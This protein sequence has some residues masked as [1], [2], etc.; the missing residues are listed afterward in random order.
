MEPG[1]IETRLADE[2]IAAK[3]LK[4]Y[5]DHAW[6]VTD[7]QK[8]EIEKLRAEN[9]ELREELVE[10]KA[11]M[12]LRNVCLVS[13]LQALK[14]P[15]HEANDFNCQDWPPDEGCRGC[16][17]DELREQ[18]ASLLETALCQREAKEA[19]DE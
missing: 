9:A 2:I 19:S 16:H 3:V 1:S 17:G 7:V 8:A 10:L 11:S 12:H 14:A 15:T 5:L 4:E 18:A 13:V 6:E